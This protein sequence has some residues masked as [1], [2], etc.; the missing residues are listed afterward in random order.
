MTTL[1][2]FYFYPK[3]VDI[4]WRI[5]SVLYNLCLFYAFSPGDLLNPHSFPSN[6]ISMIPKS[7]FI[8]SAQISPE[9]HSYIYIISNYLRYLFGCFTYNLAYKT[10]DSGLVIFL[11]KAEYLFMFSQWMES[12]PTKWAIYKSESCT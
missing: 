6:Y 1:S 7:K 5:C 10:V 2:P 8:S 9:Y 11:S 3:N 4:S 12:L